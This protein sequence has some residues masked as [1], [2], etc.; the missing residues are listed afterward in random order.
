MLV[1]IGHHVAALFSQGLEAGGP[2]ACP[3]KDQNVRWGM[4]SRP[5]RSFTD[6]KAGARGTRPAQTEKAAQRTYV[7]FGSCSL[8]ILGR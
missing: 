7:G 6:A 4:I 1:T 3:R 2:L 5:F 8:C